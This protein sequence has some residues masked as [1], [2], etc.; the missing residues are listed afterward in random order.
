MEIVSTE[1]VAKH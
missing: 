1:E